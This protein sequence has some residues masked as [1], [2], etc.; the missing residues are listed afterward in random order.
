MSTDK[1]IPFKDNEKLAAKAFYEL[2][3]L[4]FDRNYGQT[5]KS[6]I[7]LL[8]FHFCIEDILKKGDVVSD[9]NLSKQLGITQRK[10]RNLRIKEN[11]VYPRN[12]DWKKELKNQIEKA[13]YDRNTNKITI[14]IS[15]PNVLIEIQEFLQEN[16]AYIEKQLNS[17]LLIIKPNFLFAL[18]TEIEEE[19]EKIIKLIEENMDKNE[20]KGMDSK[21]KWQKSIKIFEDSN[22][23]FRFLENTLKYT[24]TFSSLFNLIKK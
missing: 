6:E 3:E 5:N 12:I 1:Y 8:M 24:I 2:C 19:K 15:D 17:R 22:T 4:F 13:D 7:E 10:V 23:L 16:G 9:Y 21:T 14:D 20:F 18:L 11:L